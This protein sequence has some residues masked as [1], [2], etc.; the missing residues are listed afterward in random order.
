MQERHLWF[1][2]SINWKR[3]HFIDR[4]IMTIYT[5]STKIFG[6]IPKINLRLTWSDSILSKLMLKT[7][8]TRS[9]SLKNR[10]E[11]LPTNDQIQWK[12]IAL[13]PV[14]FSPTLIFS[15][16]RP[17][18]PNQQTV[19][20]YFFDSPNPNQSSNW[21]LHQNGAIHLPQNFRHSLYPTPFYYQDLWPQNRAFDPHF[22]M[23]RAHDPQGYHLDWSWFTK[24][25]Y[26]RRN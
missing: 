7:A 25:P 18:Q 19:F 6:P 23:A 17:N 2:E 20:V 8:Q 14:E 24:R 13:P 11:S 15:Y 9:N 10:N 4:C 16:I 22:G 26:F 1:R 5:N 21:N 12:S 3:T